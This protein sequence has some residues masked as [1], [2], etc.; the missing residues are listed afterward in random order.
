ML[1]R[2]LFVLLFFVLSLYG[3]DDSKLL[4][5][6]ET[7]LK[8]SSKSDQFRAYNDYKNLYLRAMMDDDDSLRLSA[9]DGIVESGNKLKIDVASYEKELKKSKEPKVVAASKVAPKKAP[10]ASKPP[11]ENPKEIKTASKT[12]KAQEVKTSKAQEMKVP[13]ESKEESKKIHLTSSHKLRSIRWEGER[14]MLN[15]DKPLTQN[16]VNF[17]TIHEPNKRHYKYVFD[18]HASMLSQSE[19]LHKNGIDR[20]RIAQFNPHTLRLVIENS[21][22]IEVSF[23]SERGSLVIN[24]SSGGDIEAPSPQVAST[25]AKATQKQYKAIDRH[26]VIVIDPGHGGKDP[27]AVGYKNYREKVVVLDISKEVRAILEA[28]GYR[29]YM[30][31][32]NDKFLTLRER[33]VYAN[34]RHA[35]LFVSI[36][37]NAVPKQNVHKAHGIE[38]YFLDK[39]RSNRA[40]NVAA[41]ENSADL[42]GLNF[43]AKESFLNTLSSHNIVAAHKLAID[44]QGGMLKSLREKYRDVKDGGVRPAPFWVLVGAQMPAVLVEVGFITH[45]ME[46]Q[47]LVDKNYQKKLALGLANGIEN[48]FRNN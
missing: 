40:K 22:K 25:I 11:K 14:L 13:K 41:Q 35:D 7:F 26:K 47:R 9:L 48:Y 28:R 20:I 15:F 8:S 19:N 44:L 18:I 46:A 42:S 43:Y 32:D 29:V 16:Q 4:K 31:R 34:K 6:A 27:G 39:S 38:C 3:Q 36:H 24:T 45:T 23:K 30:T 5:R 12:P 17:F 10:T 37:A 21:K 33:T 2:A 1:L